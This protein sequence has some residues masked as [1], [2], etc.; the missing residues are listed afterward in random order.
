MVIFSFSHIPHPVYTAED[1]FALITWL[2]NV[3]ESGADAIG[4]A[5]V[6]VVGVAVVVDIPEV[7][8][9]ADI[10]RAEPPVVSRHPQNITVQ[11]P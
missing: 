6:V 9:V 4:V 1:Y 2:L 5:G 11:T 8:R 7:G 10:G 3:C